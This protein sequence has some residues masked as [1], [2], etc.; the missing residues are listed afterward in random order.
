M[1]YSIYTNNTFFIITGGGKLKEKLVKMI[2]EEYN[3]QFKFLGYTQAINKVYQVSDAILSTSLYEGL[4]YT[5]IEAIAFNKKLITTYYI[6]DL[7]EYINKQ[8]FY[9]E[10]DIKNIAIEIN[11]IIHLQ[12]HSSEL[13]EKF[14]TGFMNVNLFLIKHQNLYNKYYEFSKE[15]HFNCMQ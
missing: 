7:S 8:Y 14:E 3:C 13:I 10:G 9:I 2:P 15:K 1:K 6:K 4:P 12:K 11:R 5:Y